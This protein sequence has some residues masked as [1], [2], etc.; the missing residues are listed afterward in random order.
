MGYIFINTGY[1]VKV[2]SIIYK[3]TGNVNGKCIIL[4]AKQ[5]LPDLQSIIV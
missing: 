1:L 3:M 2:T 5:F 4:I